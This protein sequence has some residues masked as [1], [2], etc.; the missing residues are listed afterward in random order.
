MKIYIKPFSNYYCSNDKIMTYE[1]TPDSS[2]Q[3]IDECIFNCNPSVL[4]VDGTQEEIKWFEHEMQEYWF[5][6]ST[7]S[8][9]IAIQSKEFY[10][11]HYDVFETVFRETQYLDNLMNRM[12]TGKANIVYHISKGE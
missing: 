10:V 4:R 2:I 1:I 11:F 9:V 8:P 6:D 5:P 12:R 7:D 3:I